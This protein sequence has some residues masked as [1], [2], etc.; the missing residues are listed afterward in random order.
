M[1][2]DT[3]IE[4]VS[5]RAFK[6]PTDAP[7]ADGT[8]SWT[9]TTLITVHVQAGGKTGFGYTY[10]HACQTSLIETMLAKAVKQRDAMDV[11]GAWSSV[12]HQVRNIGRDGMAAMSIAAIDIALW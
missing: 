9:E 8:F 7:E 5:V 12:Q 3:P 11:E 10:G 2:A 6:I 4:S 1:R